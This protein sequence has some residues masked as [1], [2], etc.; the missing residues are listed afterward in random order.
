MIK[1]CREP[2]WARSS[3]TLHVLNGIKNFKLRIVRGQDV[4]LVVVKSVLTNLGSFSNIGSGLA[5]K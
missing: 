1:F 2:I 4:V 5:S 3:Q